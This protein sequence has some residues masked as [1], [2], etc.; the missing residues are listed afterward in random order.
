VTAGAVDQLMYSDFGEAPD[1]GCE[2]SHRRPKVEEKGE[3]NFCGLI[4]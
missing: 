1:F 2:T 3:N 4:G